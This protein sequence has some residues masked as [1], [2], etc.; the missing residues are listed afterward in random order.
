M[1]HSRGAQ[2]VWVNSSSTIS[3]QVYLTFW[4]TR[5]EL[6]DFLMFIFCILSIWKQ[7]MPWVLNEVWWAV[8]HKRYIEYWVTGTLRVY[9]LIDV[10]FTAHLNII[11]FINFLKWNLSGMNL[12]RCAEQYVWIVKNISA[13]CMRTPSH[14]TRLIKKT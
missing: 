7:H 1:L 14:L 3:C 13:K 11:F 9:L 4:L 6:V 8:A 10:F 5:R 2:D 12:C